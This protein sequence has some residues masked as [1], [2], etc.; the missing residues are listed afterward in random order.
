MVVQYDCKFPGNKWKKS[1]VANPI[2]ESGS[3]DEID[4][5][6][7]AVLKA[8]GVVKVRIVHSFRV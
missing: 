3:E 7:F 4:D 6:H 5:P 8:K 1:H 2:D